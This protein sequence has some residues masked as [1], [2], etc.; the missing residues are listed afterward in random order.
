MK[1]HL[2]RIEFQMNKANVTMTLCYTTLDRLG[3]GTFKQIFGI[4]FLFLFMKE[5]SNKTCLFEGG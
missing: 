2:P 1:N 5:F 3:I 4:E